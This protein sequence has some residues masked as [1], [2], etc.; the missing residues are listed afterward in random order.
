MQ[1][2]HHKR[3]Q[4]AI[5]SN[6]VVIIGSAPQ[7]PYGVIDNIVELAAVA[8]SRGIGFHTDACLG[9][10][11]LPWARLKHPDRVPPFDFEVPGVTSI[12]CDTHKYGYATKGTSV[13]LFENADLRRN[14]YFVT[15][16]WPGG[17]YASPTIAGSRAGGLIACCWTALMATGREKYIQHSEEIWNTVQNIKD[18]V[19]QIKGIKLMGNS[20]SSVVSWTSDDKE[21]DI[22]Q[23]AQEMSKRGW[24]LNSMHKPPAIHIAVTVKSAGKEQ[25]LLKDLKESV[26]IV[27]NKPDKKP[28]GSAAFYGIANTFPDRT[29]IADVAKTYIDTAL[30]V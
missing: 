25:E 29:L 17:T 2:Q 11:F 14:M 13:L 21:I 5:T 7:F 22:Y 27:K 1:R 4:N 18:G 26:E 20:F 19:K 28:H 30:D 9:G 10:F 12:S 6:T 3:L 15:T 8:K 24:N 23:V 16:D